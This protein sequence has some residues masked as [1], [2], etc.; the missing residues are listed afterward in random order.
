MDRN[1]IIVRTSG[2]GIIVNIFLV[3]FKAIIG[4]LANSIA[5]VLDAVNNLTDVLSSVITIVG[6]KLS[7]KAPDKEH[8]YGHGRIEYFTSIIISTIVL[9]LMLIGYSS[10]AIKSWVSK[11]TDMMN[12]FS[13]LTPSETRL[14]G[15]LLVPHQ[16]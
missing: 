13:M 4:L 14:C 2:L 12:Q 10:P 3:I 6:T 7:T 11:S 8:P 9:R 1:K 5:I 16:L 15:L